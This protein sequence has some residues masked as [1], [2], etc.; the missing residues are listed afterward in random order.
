MLGRHVHSHVVPVQDFATNYARFAPEFPFFPN[1]V[2]GA[3]VQFVAVDATP[4][5]FFTTTK[6]TVDLPRPTDPPLRRRRASPT[7]C[8]NNFGASL[9]DVPHF[10]WLFK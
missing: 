3:V 4:C 5:A 6:A 1:R 2:T 7:S 9:V 8:F 10:H